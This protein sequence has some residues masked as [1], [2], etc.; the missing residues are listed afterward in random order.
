MAIEDTG[1]SV[2]NDLGILATIKDGMK[3][4]GFEEVSF[5]VTTRYGELD[6]TKYPPVIYWISIQS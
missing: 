5:L 3:I 4:T 1:G 2:E 6:F